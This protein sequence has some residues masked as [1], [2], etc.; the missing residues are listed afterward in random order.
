MN[1]QNAV[2]IRMNGFALDALDQKQMRCL[3]RTS[4]RVMN[5]QNVV[6]IR[7]NGF[8]L[9]ALD[10]EQMRCLRRT[11]DETGVPIPNLISRALN[12][13]IEAWMAEAELPKK[14]VKFPVG[15]R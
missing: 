3:R 1:P 13:V 11:S 14:I 6:K 5:P 4:T 10:Q 9:D 2:K 15:A 12:R 7:M 8:A